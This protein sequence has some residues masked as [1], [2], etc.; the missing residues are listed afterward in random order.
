M[1]ARAAVDAALHK[2]KS[3]KKVI[4]EGGGEGSMAGRD[5]VA[6]IKTCMKKNE[7]GA[8]EP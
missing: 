3:Q 1:S 8:R 4:C 5:A 7:S 6:V 2:A